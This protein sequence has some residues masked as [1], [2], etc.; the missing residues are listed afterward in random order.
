MY[1]RIRGAFSGSLPV[2]GPDLVMY[3]FALANINMYIA[4]LK[5]MYRTL[6][7]YSPIN[8][9]TVQ[10]LLGAYGLTPAMA[11]T[12]ASERI[13]FLGE[14]NRLIAAMRTFRVPALFDVFNRYVWLCD[15]VFQDSQELKQAQLYV[16]NPR[17]FYQASTLNTPDGVEATGLEML[18]SPLDPSMTPSFANSVAKP[19]IAFGDGLIT[20][21]K[22]TAE[23]LDI[24][25]YLDRAFKTTTWFALNEVD[26]RDL[27]SPTYNEEV[28]TQIENFR[29]IPGTW[30]NTSIKDIS[31]MNI[32]QDP[33]TNA[34][35]CSNAVAFNGVY[36][37]AYLSSLWTNHLN[38]RGEFDAAKATIATRMAGAL[39]S[40]T[41]SDDAGWVIQMDTATEYPL[42]MRY[43]TRANLKNAVS[44]FPGIIMP[45]TFA[46]S[47][48]AGA[49]SFTV[50]TADLETFDWHPFVYLFALDDN[51]A[52]T[53]VGVRGDIHSFTTFLS[54]T[55]NDIHRNCMYS[56]FNAFSLI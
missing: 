48:T 11:T 50:E 7:S 5:R 32:S 4:W 23:A 52:A 6:L 38:I 21:L 13:W 43:V 30:V 17:G 29:G 51:N 41:G 16:F 44:S 8:Y 42:W 19:L 14:I 26:E 39:K 36:N 15:N 40:I 55:L 34:V 10:V 56:E 2:D 3:M 49:W 1:A 22:S 47:L 54:D 27:I 45:Q 9:T 28:L 31:K 46:M 37:A 35:L 25:G 18:A 20:S 12:L 33:K 24:N 53:A